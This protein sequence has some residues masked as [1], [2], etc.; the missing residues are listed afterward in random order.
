MRMMY[1]G[2]WA[3][4]RFVLVGRLRKGA[5]RLCCWDEYMNMHVSKRMKRSFVNDVQI[6]K[7]QKNYG[8]V[9]MELTYK[10]YD[11]FVGTTSTPGYG[12]LSL[13]TPTTWYLEL[14]RASTRV[15]LVTSRKCGGLCE[16]CF[17]RICS[18]NW[19]TEIDHFLLT[20]LKQY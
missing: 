4:R 20:S 10:D 9:S 6:E 14:F 12:T 15:I 5:G 13:C 2:I 8:I 3:S 17:H 19:T 1:W 11:D 16:W 18:G 7:C